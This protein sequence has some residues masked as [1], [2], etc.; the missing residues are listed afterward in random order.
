MKFTSS[1]D[2]PLMA[3]GFTNRT[4]RFR[5]PFSAD[6]RSTCILGSSDCRFSRHA[7]TQP[8]VNIHFVRVA[9]RRTGEHPH[10]N[11]ALRRLHRH[12]L[13]ELET[14]LEF[15]HALVDRK[16]TS[17]DEVGPEHLLTNGQK[18]VNLLQ[19]VVP[20]VLLSQFRMAV[21]LGGNTI[22][23]WQTGFATLPS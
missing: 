18:W 19:A 15:D 23:S 21:V 17:W 20:D 12:V 9:I 3:A 14:P 10:L 2:T 13:D 6:C 7:V 16:F 11:S 4:R 8:T 5:S 22:G 1:S